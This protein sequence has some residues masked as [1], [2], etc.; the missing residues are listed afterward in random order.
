MPK[1]LQLR[2]ITDDECKELQRISR[3]RTEVARRVERA[4]IILALGNKERVATLAERY[5]RSLPMIYQVLHRFNE[6]GLEAL[7]DAPKSGRPPIYSEEQRGQLIAVARTHPQQ[8][9]LRFGQWT[10]ERLV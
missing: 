8:L 1:R 5:Q 7:E 6:V 10:L 9:A 4:K 2:V 3:S